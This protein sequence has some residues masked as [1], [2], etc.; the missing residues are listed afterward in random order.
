MRLSNRQLTAFIATAATLSFTRA[1]KQLGITQ[2]AL[3]QRIRQ[4]ENELGVTL[5]NRSSRGVELTEAGKRVLRFCRSSSALEEEILSDLGSDPSGPLKGVTRIAAHSSILRPVLIPALAP[6]LRENPLVKCEFISAEAK[7]LP[8]ILKGGEAEFV[9][10]DHLLDWS[11]LTTHELGHETYVAVAST[12]HQSRENVYLDLDIHDRVTAEFF[13]L[14][15]NPPEY[16][17]CFLSDVFGIIAGVENGL[18]RAV[19][20]Q[21]LIVDNPGVKVLPEY[22]PIPSPIILHFYTQSLYT[23]LHSIVL[24][25]ILSGCNWYLD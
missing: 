4:L 5:L 21:H 25:T 6:L 16:C 12:V 20:S 1:A 10:M 17:R 7:D 13:N 2:S 18:G 3:S 14:Q 19:V 11:N 15:D 24:E 22:K 9:I 23:R 8:D